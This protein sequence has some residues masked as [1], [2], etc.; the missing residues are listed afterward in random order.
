[1]IV[2]PSNLHMERTVFNGPA[3]SSERGREAVIELEYL[4]ILGALTLCSLGAAAFWRGP[5]Q[6]ARVF[7]AAWFVIAFLPVSNIV[8]LNATVAEHWLYL[9]SVG[10][11]IFLAGCVA[12]LRLRREIITGA[13]VVF[14]IGLSARSF[15]RSSDWVDPETFYQRTAAAGGTSCRVSVNLAQAYANRGEYAKAEALFRNVLRIQPDYTIARNNLAN[16]LS[17]L[18]RDEEA[19]QVLAEA[20]AGARESRREYPRTWIAALNYAR[21]LDSRHDTAGALD[22]LQKARIDYPQ[23]WEVIAYESELYR[24]QNQLAQAIELVRPY[25]EKT[26]WH[27]TSWMALGRLYAENGDVDLAERTLRHASW[28]DVRATD[29]LNLIA[30]MQMRQNRLPDAFAS[31][32]RAVARQPE[33]PRQYVLLSDILNRMGRADE[34]RAALARVSRLRSL[35]EAKTAN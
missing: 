23:T 8:D 7:G 33:Q 13:L 11:L 25:A 18:G 29:P 26:W 15:S 21:L 17:N 3:F 31:Q 16:A 24:R 1:L 20:T 2:F 27:Y 28:L 34:A 30:L 22:V 4:S 5:A 9:P 14:I 32:R 19:K 10:A 12:E 6:R 35:A